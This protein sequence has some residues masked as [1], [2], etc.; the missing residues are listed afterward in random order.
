MF[1]TAIVPEIFLLLAAVCGYCLCRTIQ[2]VIHKAALIQLKAI[3]QKKFADRSAADVGQ[4]LVCQRQLRSIQAAYVTLRDK[5][6][7]E[8]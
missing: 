2:S 3:V 5:Y 1:Y 7:S 6:K 8:D 4:L